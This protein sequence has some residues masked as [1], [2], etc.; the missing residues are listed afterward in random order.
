MQ[1]NN[2]KIKVIF[3]LSI[4]ALTVFLYYLNLNSSEQ[5]AKEI[6]ALQSADL[7]QEAPEQISSVE[8][9]TP[10]SSQEKSSETSSSNK[11]IIADVKAGLPE[12]IK[13]LEELE[14][15]RQKNPNTFQKMED[16]P[17][18]QQAEMKSWLQAYQENGYIEISDVN[19]D[20]LEL[21]NNSVTKMDLN[22]PTITV[23]LQNIEDTK[24]SEYEY[25]GA[26]LDQYEGAEGLPVEGVKR[27]YNDNDGH[28]ITLYEK[29]IINSAPLLI[30]EFVADQIKGYPSTKMTYCTAS[31]DRC[32][33]KITLITKDKL[34][35]VT[36]NGDKESTKDKLVEIAGS[37]DLPEIEQPL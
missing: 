15:Q 8:Q 13:R 19:F 17:I 9:T 28:E 32:F 26:T 34:Y 22:D 2:K 7:K 12:E 33:S 25:R 23:A 16:L 29:S 3:I 11:K 6:Q 18:E 20:H 27:F 1:T 36:I 24:L 5:E 10:Y 30:E 4:M 37:L 21:Q 31:E 35:E 14:E